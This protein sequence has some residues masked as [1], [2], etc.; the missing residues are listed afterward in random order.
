MNP[1]Y[2]QRLEAE[3]SRELKTLPELTA[4]PALANRVLAALVQRARIPWYRRSWQ[5]WP[6]ALQ[7]ASLAVLLGLF[8]GL[9]L[10]GWELS[11]TGA[12]TLALHQAGEWFSGLNLIADTFNVLMNAVAL[13]LKKLGTGFIV[14]G[15]ILVG[16]GYALCVGL[17]TV[18]FRLAFAKR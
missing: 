3:I 11:Q 17:G 5:T 18:Y 8:G 6:P 1:D 10:A 14:T 13:V 15:L 4:P 12:V 7:A 9:C 16:M 2:D